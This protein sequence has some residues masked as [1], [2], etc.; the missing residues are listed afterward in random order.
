MKTKMVS[1]LKDNN[2]VQMKQP[3]QDLS[4]SPASK[5]LKAAVNGDMTAFGE[6]YRLYSEPI[7]RYCSYRVTN[8][9]DA[10][11]LT[12]QV[13]LRAWQ[14]IG[15]YQ[16]G[17]APFEAWL[18]RIAH[19]LVINYQQNRRLHLEMAD[20]GLDDHFLESIEDSEKLTSNPFETAFKRSSATLCTRRCENCRSYSNR[21]FIFVLLKVGA[22]PKSLK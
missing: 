17:G 14:A 20:A 4:C 9:H 2:P 6:L 18:Y 19:N 1:D 5:Y 13:F 22:M 10:E 11:D 3:H 7:F 21:Y 8:E 16:I 12:A 15:R